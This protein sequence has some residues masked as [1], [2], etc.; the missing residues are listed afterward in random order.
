MPTIHRPSR[1]QVPLA[2][3]S[4]AISDQLAEPLCI[5]TIR[6]TR[7]LCAPR[8]AFSR[9]RAA[10][11]QR[12]DRALAALNGVDAES[13]GTFFVWFR[14]PD[15]LTAERLLVEHRLV[16]APGEGFGTRGEGYARL[17]LAVTDEILAAGLD[18]LA[19]ALAGGVSR[20]SAKRT[21][22]GGSGEPGGSPDE[23]HRAPEVH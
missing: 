3:R 18:R 21:G 12:R 2:R 10:Y 23:D 9:R 6:R 20:P 11:G 15:G 8:T 14:L 13:E 5:S 7:R 1:W 17:S 16:V 4:P 22:G 19:A